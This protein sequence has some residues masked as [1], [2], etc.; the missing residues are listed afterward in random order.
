MWPF[1]KPKPVHVFIIRNVL[2]E[3]IDRVEGVRD[4]IN[5]DLRGRQW[6]SVDLSGMSLYG[7]NLEG[8][9]LIG[10]R[11]VRTSFYR[12]N[13]MGA[14]LSYCDAWGADF[15][16]ANLVGTTLYRSNV[17]RARFDGSIQNEHTDIPGR[18]VTGLVRVVA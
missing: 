8:A 10:G 18:R 16:N 2:G 13:L 15:Q 9:N 6:P 17:G 5:A 11:F 7:A 3:E 1:S 4:L 12:A 14:E